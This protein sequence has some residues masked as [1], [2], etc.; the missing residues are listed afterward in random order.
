MIITRSPLRI[1]LGG[2]GTDL[3]PYVHEHGGFCL[4][5][6]ID[7]YVYITLHQR[8]DDKLVVKYSDVEMVSQA[9]ELKHPLTREALG[10][11][12]MDGKGLEIASHADIPAG[13]G[14]GS[15]GA[16]TCALLA[17]LGASWYLTLADR[18]CEVEI[19]RALEPVGK[20][21]PYISAWGGIRAMTFCPGGEV[22]PERLA[23][24][25]DHLE[26][27][28]L[29]FF[30]G[31]TRRARSIL[32]EAPKMPW[33]EV[34]DLGLKSADALTEGRWAE[35]ADL[36]TQQWLLKRASSP[37]MTNPQIDGWFNRARLNGALGGKLVGAGG[38]GFLLF[39]AEEPQRLR[40]AM[41]L[42][43]VRFRFDWEGTKVLVS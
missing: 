5:A 24:E 25:S 2:G 11:L 14:L 8:F 19:T 29:L 10:L 35:F 38:G 4:S 27:H 34:K 12:G 7:K 1:T 36:L 43:E 23:V 21:D 3:P 22:D 15:S 33:D 26:D 17:A 32:A 18:A 9:S 37:K 20:Q 31:Y 40:Q 28:L 41:E 13:T 6:A 39:Y 30:T 16:F 42:P